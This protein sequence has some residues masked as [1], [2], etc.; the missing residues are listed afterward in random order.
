MTY[1][2][3]TSVSE[4]RSR[5]EIE[6]HLMKYGASRFG[7]MR[8]ERTATIVF[9][10]RRLNIRMEIPLPDPADKAFALTDSRKWKRR[11]E[12]AQKL[13]EQEV[14]RRWRSLALAIKAKLVAVEDGVATF[15]AE[16]MPYM[17]AADGLTIAQKMLPMIEAA[18]DG[19]MLPATLALPDPEERP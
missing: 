12:E 13:Y 15:E 14:R 6:K 16:F 2:S 4:E 19:G 18:A 5:A 9:T 10:Y 7:Y 11:P 17:V 3:S 1:A 8:E